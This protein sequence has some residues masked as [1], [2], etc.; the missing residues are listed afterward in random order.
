MIYDAKRLKTALKG[1][2]LAAGTDKTRAFLHGV[3][4]SSTSAGHL[5]LCA[6]DGHRLHLVQFGAPFSA[7]DP[8][9]GHKGLVATADVKRI[10]GALPAKGQVSV[11]LHERHL[12]A[13][14]LTVPYLEEVFPPYLA[15]SKAPTGY[16]CGEIGIDVTYLEQAA[17]FVSSLTQKNDTGSRISRV[18]TWGVLDPVHLGH[19]DART[20][21]ATLAIVMPCRI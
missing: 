7:K 21:I 12:S 10:I 19:F 1:V 15:V 17:K 18:C 9:V 4:F 8:D 13:G 11:E 2:L 5:R 14:D 6:A 3:H 16:P 20:E